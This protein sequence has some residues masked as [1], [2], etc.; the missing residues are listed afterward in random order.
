MQGGGKVKGNVARG[1][2]WGKRWGGF[3]RVL[4]LY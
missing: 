3:W 2:V 1:K 4:P